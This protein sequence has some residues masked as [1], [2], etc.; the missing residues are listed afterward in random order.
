VSEDTGLAA[1]PSDHLGQG[2]PQGPG[3]LHD[4]EVKGHGEHQDDAFGRALEPLDEATAQAMTAGIREAIDD[5]RCSV[6]VLADRVR[7]AHEARVWVVLGYGSWASYAEAE[8]GISRAQAYRL[9]DIAR[10]LGTIKAAV[11]TADQTATRRRPRS[12]S[13]CPSGRSWPWPA[14]PTTSRR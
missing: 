6:A 11:T 3:A 5:V 9:L 12:T 8:F 10:A 2:C 7:A 1:A 4:G 13:G 14:A